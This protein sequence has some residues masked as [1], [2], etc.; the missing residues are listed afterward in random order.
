MTRIRKLEKDFLAADLSA[1]ETMLGQLAEDDFLTRMSLE[2][3]RDELQS[4]LGEVQEDERPVAAAALFF[5]GNPVVGCQGI[6][7]EFGGKAIS[8]F[9]DLVAKQF[10]LDSGRLGQRG[11]VQNKAATRLH[12]TNIVRGS[13]GFLLEDLDAQVSMIESSL[14]ESVDH[15]SKLMAAFGE[16]DEEQFEEAVENVDER[17]LATTRDF[18]SLMQTDGAT[19]RL[20]VG[21]S[22]RSFNSASIERAASRAASTDVEDVDDEILGNFAGALPDGHLFEMRVL[23]ARGVIR[24]KVDA[25][26][27]PN[28]LEMWNRDYVGKSTR[29][30]VT[31][32]RV[33]KENE[34]VRENFT[35]HELRLEGVKEIK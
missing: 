25:S 26:I 5:G 22:D 14:S 11:V 30:K 4:E 20:V 8:T 17:V 9:Q 35:L 6:E 19:F 18:F 27:P 13:F 34:V 21:D 15:V 32:R 24:G 23:D 3:R 7:S 1:V 28:S 10:A 29:A 33:L 12:V 31:V 16:V 2:E